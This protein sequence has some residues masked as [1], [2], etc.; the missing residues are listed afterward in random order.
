L[1]AAAD[2]SIFNRGG[3]IRGFFRPNIATTAAKTRIE[4]NM[5]GPVSVYDVIAFLFFLVCWPGYRLF[6]SRFEA[7]RP[8]LMSLVKTFRRQWITRMAERDSHIADATLLGN[9][10]RGSLFFA[11]TTVLI[12]GGLVALLG[13][14]PKIAELVSQMPFA[15]PSDPI[16]AEVKA[17]VLILVYVYAFFK[18][19][20]AAWQY[21]VLSILVG[22]L[23]AR[24]GDNVIRE[25][26][27][28]AAGQVAALAG[29]SYNNGV[30]AYYFSIP[31][32]AW[33]ADPILFFA[34]TLI[35]TVVLYR[36][37][38]NSPIM[39]ALRTVGH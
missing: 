25:Q 37:E 30:R 26:Y 15:S 32:M 7:K 29:E 11:S 6:A 36:R 35:V 31:L 20:W 21:N 19:T 3:R 28:E 17:V 1:A 34:G 5:I 9:L 24:S 13:I 33:L 23:P 2:R 12:L 22:A 27:V 16:V 10:L 38:F 8:G 39:N 18:F 14:A 4:K